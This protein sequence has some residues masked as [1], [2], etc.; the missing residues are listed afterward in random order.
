MAIPLLPDSNPLCMAASFQLTP[1]FTHS[2]IELTWLPQF[3][4]RSF[5]YVK[6][7][8]GNMFTEPFPSSDRLFLLIT[9]LLP[10]NGRRSVVCF[11]AVA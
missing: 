8:R 1:F 2:L 4:H 3:S 6:R 9:N 10:C 7:F 11:A 5:S